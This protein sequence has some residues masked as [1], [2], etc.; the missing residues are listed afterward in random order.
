MKMSNHFAPVLARQCFSGRGATVTEN[1]LRSISLLISPLYSGMPHYEHISHSRFVD[2]PI[3]LHR[4][5]QHY[6]LPGTKN[7]SSVTKHA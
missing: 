1:K 2:T 7:K 4:L 6:S 3:T 5:I